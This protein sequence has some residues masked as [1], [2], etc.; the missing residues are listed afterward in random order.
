MTKLDSL[1]AE[2]KILRLAFSSALDALYKIGWASRGLDSSYRLE[3]PNLAKVQL[4]QIIFDALSAGTEAYNRLNPV[5]Y[6]TQKH[7]SL[8]LELD[9]AKDEAL[10][11]ARFIFDLRDEDKQYDKGYHWPDLYHALEKV[12]KFKEKLSLET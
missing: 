12:K 2:N 7:L 8:Q 1:I 5:F 9:F 3:L 4:V 10:K 11:I 6:E